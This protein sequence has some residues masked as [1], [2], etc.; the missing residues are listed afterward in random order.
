DAPQIEVTLARREDD[1][2]ALGG[3][4]WLGVEPGLGEAPHVRALRVH[5]E[6]VSPS[7]PLGHEGDLAAGRRPRGLGVDAAVGGQPAEGSAGEVEHV[8]LGVAVA[9]EGQSYRLAV[10]A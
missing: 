1:R 7:G 6:D 5:H 9:G 8:D 2:V 3:P 10:R 4:A